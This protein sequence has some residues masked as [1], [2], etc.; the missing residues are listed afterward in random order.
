MCLHTPRCNY[1]E[2]SQSDG[3]HK[4]SDAHKSSHLPDV[5]RRKAPTSLSQVKLGVIKGSVHRI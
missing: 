5:S 2:R 4:E 3:G 1:S